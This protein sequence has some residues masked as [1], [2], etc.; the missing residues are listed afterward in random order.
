MGTSAAIVNTPSIVL[1]DGVCNLCNGTIQFI[2][3]RDKKKRFRFASLQSDVG[4]EQLKKNGLSTTSLYSIILIEGDNVYDQ[5]D[6]A[7]RIA[8]H[9]S[10]IWPVLYSFI[11]FPKGLRDAV[12]G[13]I[14]RNRYRFFGRQDQCMLPTPDIKARF[15]Q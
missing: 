13:F 3:K 15:I 10:G 4:Q 12:Y 1:F 2:I 7:L 6:A 5:S 11:V 8:K 9:L 14:A